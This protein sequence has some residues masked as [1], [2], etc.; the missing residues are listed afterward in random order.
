MPELSRLL[1]KRWLNGRPAEIWIAQLDVVEGMI[2]EHKL[3]PLGEEHY[4][5]MDITHHLSPHEAHMAQMD[6]KAANR[7][8]QVNPKPFP[9]GLRH[10]HLHFKDEIYLLD[11][12]LWREFSTKVIRSL[13]DRLNRARTVS[14]DQLLEASAGVDAL[15]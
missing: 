7:E 2:N 15:P 6:A 10:P 9:G 1:I 4:P 3:K 8:V 12:K 13:K 14:F 11:N 5:V